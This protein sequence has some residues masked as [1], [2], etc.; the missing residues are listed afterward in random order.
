ML[1]L[2]NIFVFI[3]N[4]D[5]VSEN[6]T[7]I[8]YDTDVFQTHQF[9]IVYRKTF[10]EREHVSNDSIGLHTIPENVELGEYIINSHL[11]DTKNR[12]YKRTHRS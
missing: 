8:Y 3:I 9:N 2:N 1:L 7:R 6:S 12:D 4:A 11:R 5:Y 10:V